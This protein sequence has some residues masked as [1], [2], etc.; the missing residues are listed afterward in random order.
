MKTIGTMLPDVG[1]ATVPRAEKVTMSMLA[2]RNEKFSAVPGIG[3]VAP[4]AVE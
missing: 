1:G 3:C 4:D 2:F